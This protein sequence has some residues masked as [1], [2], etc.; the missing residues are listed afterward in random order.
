MDCM[1]HKVSIEH[2][3]GPERIIWVEAPKPMPAEREVLVRVEAAGV[4]FGDVLLR[5]GVAG[6]RFPVTPGYDLVGVVEAIGPGASRFAIG[7]RVAGF[8][9]QGGQQER[10]CLPESELVPVPADVSAEK[11]AVIL[12]Y[13][14]ALQILKRGASSKPG[15]SVF[16]YGLSGGLGSAMRQIAPRMGVR[17]YGTASGSRL[18]E[19]GRGATAFDR[20][21][22][23]WV[24]EARRAEPAGFG[25]VLD[26]IGGDSLSRSFG[27]LSGRGTLLMLGAAD[28]VQG[29]GSPRIKLI[30]T[31][32]RFL[33][34]K[35]RSGSRRVRLFMVEGPKKRPHEF[36]EHMALLFGWLVDGS[37]DPAIDMTLPLSEARKAQETLE[38]GKVQ[39][40]IVLL[41]S[42]S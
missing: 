26:P 20:M 9:G 24:E 39:G 23:N 3:G 32:A 36:S 33:W 25:L 1:N 11:A 31:L 28:S 10:V 37:I 29:E 18:A 14:T 27:L 4:A 19:A 5:R 16:L 13:L 8:P 6:G 42:P 34:L 2:A 22:P 35:L 12:N 38:S 30:A 40:K 7:D 21:R 41:A 15:D 17:L